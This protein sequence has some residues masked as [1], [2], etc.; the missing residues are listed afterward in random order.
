M[1]DAAAYSYISMQQA[2]ADA[3]LT[4]EQ[5]SN[6]R[7]GLIMGSG[8]ASSANQVEAA[9]ILREKGLK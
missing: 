5:V 9:D 7:T 1:G 4:D 8:G 3:G 6:I 2:I